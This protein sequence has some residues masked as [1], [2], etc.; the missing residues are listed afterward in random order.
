MPL[1]EG[2]PQPTPAE[3]QQQYQRFHDA[4]AADGALEKF[5]TAL[6]EVFAP[7]VEK[8][9]IEKLPPE[10]DANNETIS[11]HPVGTDTKFPRNVQVSDVLLENATSSLQ[12]ALSAKMPSPEVADRVFAR[13]KSELKGTLKLNVEATREGTERKGRRSQNANGSNSGGHRSGPRSG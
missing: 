2:T 1:A 3:R 10:H 12:K 5:K 4:L 9:L 11:V 13:L 8:G 7:L 6:G